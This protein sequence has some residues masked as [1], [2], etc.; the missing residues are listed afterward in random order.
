[1]LRVRDQGLQVL[2]AH[3]GA[4]AASL[5]A[6]TPPASV[7]LP[8]QATSGAVGSACAA[9]DGVITTLARRAQT[10]ATKAALSNGEFIATDGAG[11]HAVASITQV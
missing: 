3:C 11:A 2:A 6:A 8:V 7:G 1:M 10:S 9:I 4:V 5:I